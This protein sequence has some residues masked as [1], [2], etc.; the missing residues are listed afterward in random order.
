MRAGLRLAPATLACLGVVLLLGN[1]RQVAEWSQLLGCSQADTRAGRLA[2]TPVSAASG[3]SER[4]PAGTFVLEREALPRG[5][6]GEGME[7]IHL[8]FA[9]ASVHELLVNWAAHIR[10]LRLPAVIA[11]MD[12]VVLGQCDSLRVHCLAMFDAAMDAAMTAEAQRQGQRDASAV[13][14]RG[15][16]TLFISLGARKVEAILTL[17]HTS[18]RPVLTS[19][20]D[21]VWMGDPTALVTGRLAGYEDFAHADLLLSTDC[22]DPQ[23][24]RD[25]HGCFHELLDRNTGVLLVR[26]STNG[27]ATMRA[28]KERTAGAFQAWETDQTAFDDLLRGRGHGHRRNMTGEQR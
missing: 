21:V 24:D 28:W 11:A 15:N 26:N 13:N 4:A 19:D 2:P 18:G 27:V 23:R 20:V 22:L 12:G 6:P 3:C 1:A 17:L 8:T 16:P 9:T 14:I 10:R 7:P 25:D 5:L